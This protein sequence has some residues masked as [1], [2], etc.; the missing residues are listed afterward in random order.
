[1]ETTTL[2]TSQQE[3][4]QNKQLQIADLRS[5]KLWKVLGVLCLAG[6]V[7]AYHR[8][9]DFWWMQ[10]WRDNSEYSHGVLIPFMSAFLIWFEWNR[11]RRIPIKPNPVGFLL[12]VP[13]IIV[14]LAANRAGIASVS[15]LTFPVVIGIIILLILGKEAVKAM[16][17][18]ILFLFFMCVP[19]SSILEGLSF[20]IQMLSTQCATL[21]LKL[22][23]L[24]VYRHGQKIQLPGIE[25]QVAEAC[26][27]FR[28]LIALLAFTTFFAY[29][30]VGPL[31]GRLSLIAFVI[32][33]SLIANSIRVL[34]IVLVGNYYGEDAMHTFHDYS[35][36]LVLVIAF[37]ALML[38][39]MVVK[40]QD[41][42][43]MPAR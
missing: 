43:T 14:Q 6:I 21:G 39:S 3:L 20:K 11:I 9:F 15:G 13:V 38:L 5:G 31:W 2:D 19:P 8:T 42:K 34:L 36:F 23:G 17:F 25:V 41:F 10:W 40:C 4:S 28:M 7:Y 37:I 18:P 30:K 26:S 22:I 1:M 24:D 33:L 35:G 16:W 32:P 12:L 27:G 29:M